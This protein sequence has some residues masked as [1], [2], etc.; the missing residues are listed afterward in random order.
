MLFRDKNNIKILFIWIRKSMVFYPFCSACVRFILAGCPSARLSLLK[1]CP[2]HLKIQVLSIVCWQPSKNI[3]C[4]KINNAGF[5]RH[6]YR[7]GAKNACTTHSHHRQFRFYLAI[8]VFFV[9]FFYAPEAVGNKSNREQWPSSNSR[10]RYWQD[11]RP[12][13]GNVASHDAPLLIIIPALQC[14]LVVFVS[15]FRAC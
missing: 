11:G 14:A 5:Y 8:Y 10:A 12:G 2:E 6:Y 9:I 4:T 7:I 3:F 1:F 15:G 13:A